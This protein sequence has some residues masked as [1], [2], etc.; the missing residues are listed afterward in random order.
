MTEAVNVDNFATR[1]QSLLLNEKG[2]WD[3]TT[4]ELKPLGKCQFCGH[5]SEFGYA[6][7]NIE[8]NR[9]LAVGTTCVG[10]MCNLDRYKLKALQNIERKAKFQKRYAHL[11]PYLLQRP[12]HLN[13]WRG[14]MAICA[15]T[16]LRRVEN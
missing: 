6:I 7:R 11:V 8:D 2:K 5:L 9:V 13:A 16:S 1:Y 3:M 14:S 4:G 12:Q 15:S 10:V